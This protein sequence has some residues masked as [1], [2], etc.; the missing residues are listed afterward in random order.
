M[1]EQRQCKVLLVR[2]EESPT[3]QA[4]RGRQHQRYLGLEDSSLPP[5]LLSRFPRYIGSQR[6]PGGGEKAAGS[7]VGEAS[8]SHVIR[9]LS[10]SAPTG[11]ASEAGVSS[12]QLLVGSL[13]GQI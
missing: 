10:R 6:W 7:E 13:P 4:G 12:R 2:D 5:S 1:R 3:N 8:A 9:S 11:A